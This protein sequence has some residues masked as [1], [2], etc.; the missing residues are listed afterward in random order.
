MYHL[1]LQRHCPFKKIKKIKTELQG[2]SNEPS[3]GGGQYDG[4]LIV[5]M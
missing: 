1:E 4:R 2:L 3:K 5:Q